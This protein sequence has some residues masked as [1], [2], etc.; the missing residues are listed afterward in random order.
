MSDLAGTTA[1]V[2]GATGFLG[3]V[4]VRRLA[5]EGVRVRALARR[6]NRERFIAGIENVEIVSGDV[7]EAQRL[8]ELAQ[9][10]DFIFHV[11]AT[12]GASVAKQ[13]PVNAEGTRH[14][15]QA[16]EDAGVKRV[17]HVSTIAIYGFPTGGIIRE[18]APPLPTR[19][20]YNITKLEGEQ[21]L[22]RT[23]KTVPYSII[24]PAMIY[25]PNSA[26]WTRNLFNLAKR[27]P[28][29]FVGDGSGRAH[30][31]FVDD[32]VDLMVTLATHPRAAG[33]AFNC[34]P[35]PAPTWREFLGAYSR[36]AGH[37]RWLALPVPLVKFLAPLIEGV[38]TLRGEPQDVPK[39]I[40]Y[41]T[42]QITYSMQKA[43]DLLG[44]QGQVTLEDG[45]Q[46]CVPYL[47]EKG[48]LK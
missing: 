45:I 12:L 17:V 23:A 15:M 46:R 7:T 26:M 39:I 36:L 25:G 13:R 9:G 8:H 4:L 42:G 28:T 34:A 40:P 24:R 19:V 30:P 31:I 43:R 20:P 32:V 41:M 18:A 14:V 33:E 11:A 47:R 21:V 3:G 48:L 35:D 16:A 22:I 10:C 29:L 2:T 5:A 38:L 44:W 1:L 37:D 27:R 6:A